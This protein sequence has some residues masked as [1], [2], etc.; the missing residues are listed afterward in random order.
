MSDEIELISDGDGLAVIGDATAVERF[1]SSAGVPSI[2][3][4]LRQKLGS[5]LSAGSGAA[6]AGSQIT[7]NSG[8]WVRLTE[9]SATALKLGQAMKGSS[10]GVS[11]AIATTSK[12]KV[13]K[14]LEFAK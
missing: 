2:D 10:E 8:R 9:E 14:I 4:Q 1:L 11:R 6:K 5:S 3:M 13:T 7:A 12:G